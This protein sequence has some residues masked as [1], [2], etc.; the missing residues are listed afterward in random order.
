MRTALLPLLLLAACD[1]EAP[2]NDL[3]ATSNNVISGDIVF[4]GDEVP[5]QTIVFVTSANDPMPPTG[6]GSP[7]TFT[8]T[9]GEW[10]TGDG[11]GIQAAPYTA[12][13][14]PDGDWLLTG[15]VDMDDDFNGTAFRAG[16][17]GASGPFGGAT[18]GDWIGGHLAD[19]TSTDL[20]PITVAG[21]EYVDDVSLFMA[22]ELTTE[23]PSFQIADLDGDG[24][25]DPIVIDRA[26]SD[27]QFYKLVTTPIHAS[28]QNPDGET[29]YYDLDGPFDGTAP[30]QAG[31]LY[32]ARDLD[33]DGEVDPHP[34]FPDIHELADA[35]PRIGLVYMGQPIDADADGYPEAFSSGLEPGEYYKSLGSVDPRYWM[36]NLLPVGEQVLITELDVAWLPGG[37]HGV[38]Q[39]DGTVVEESITDPMDL[40]AGM[41]SITVI[42][43]TGQTWSIPNGLGGPDAASTDASYDTSGQVGWLELR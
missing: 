35:W 36:M 30:C 5:G 27:S 2:L 17:A 6:T 38:P 3:A 29:L 22:V 19:L 14:I 20:A 12:T 11:A 39:A 8:T 37:I 28:F 25:P 1:Y 18:C 21:G 24:S 10:Y 26:E 33:G 7:A 32:H 15:M 9:P 41:W 34:D 13:N 16:Y 40:P 23:R 42:L 4:T 31:F 43:E